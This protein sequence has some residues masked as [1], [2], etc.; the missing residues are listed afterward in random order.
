MPAN[1]NTNKTQLTEA[2][3]EEYFANIADDARRADCRAL[4]K[5][6]AAVTHEKPRMWGAGIG[7]FG[8]Y[9][10]RYDSGREGDM[11]AVGFSSRANGISLYVV[12]DTPEQKKLLAKLGKH[13]AAKVCVTIRRMADV[14]AHVLKAVVKGSVAEVRRRYG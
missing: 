8:S 6:I 5:L 14:D 13:K 12:A 3:V 1:R 4:A 11:C 2:S 9:H 10:Y 7:G